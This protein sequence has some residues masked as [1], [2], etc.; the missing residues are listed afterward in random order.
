MRSVVN[1]SQISDPWY[2]V[3]CKTRKEH[4]AAS[5]LSTQLGLTVYLPEIKIRLQ[6]ENRRVPFFS[7]YFFIQT[8]LSRVGIS[9]INSMPGV[10]KLLDFGDGPLVVPQT[11]I[12]MI[13]EEINRQSTCC[14]FSHQKIIPGDSVQVKEGPLL[15]LKA[16]FLESLTSGE[17]AHVLLHFLGR[18]SKVQMNI[19]SLEKL[20]NEPSQRKRLTRG[21]GRRINNVTIAV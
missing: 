2:V 9:T 5:I 7:G 4:L 20:S 17:R 15:G 14:D 18:L 16:V 3:H 11:L 8:N 10:L 21:K 6:R 13:S 19:G 12:E 1:I